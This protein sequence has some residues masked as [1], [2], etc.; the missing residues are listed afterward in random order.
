MRSC[1]PNCSTY[2]KLASLWRSSVVLR[3]DAEGLTTYQFENLGFDPLVHAVFTRLGGVSQAPFDTLNVGHR[4]GDD[5]EAVAV[6][7]AWPGPQQPGCR[8]HRRG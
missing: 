2:A 6:N 1:L 8:G 4:V 3:Q 7:H 5:E